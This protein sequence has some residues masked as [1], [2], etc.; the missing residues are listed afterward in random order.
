G[1]TAQPADASTTASRSRHLPG[2]CD[3]LHEDDAAGS[4]AC[5]VNRQDRTVLRR[6]ID[7]MSTV[8]ASK[9]LEYPHV[10]LVGVEE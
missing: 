1:C 4:I 5:A 3:T 2:H 10:F 6:K 9:G 8:H 7:R